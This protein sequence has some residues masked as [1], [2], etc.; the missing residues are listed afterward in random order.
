[1]VGHDGIIVDCRFGSTFHY[2]R[3]CAL[4][5]QFGTKAEQG[6]VPSI[7]TYGLQIVITHRAALVPIRL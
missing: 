5:R 6:L 3:K 4:F 1:M 2:I 7:C